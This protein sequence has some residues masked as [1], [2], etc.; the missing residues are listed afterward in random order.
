MLAITAFTMGKS[1]EKPS[2]ELVLAR[3]GLLISDTLKNGN[4]TRELLEKFSDHTT[5]YGLFTVLQ[6]SLKLL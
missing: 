6:L 4:L 5:R 3:S 1:Q 2:E